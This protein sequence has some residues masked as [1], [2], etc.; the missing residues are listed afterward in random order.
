ME[1][2]PMFT[3]IPGEKPRTARIVA[4]V[5]GTAETFDLQTSDGKDLVKIFEDFSVEK[6]KIHS[7]AFLVGKNT[8]ILKHYG[9]PTTWEQLRR[10]LIAQIKIV[11]PTARF[12]NM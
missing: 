6:E 2:I 12:A 10:L 5:H 11:F 7:D 1:K 8:I 9:G 4:T 3:W